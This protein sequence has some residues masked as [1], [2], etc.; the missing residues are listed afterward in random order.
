MTES[1]W[2]ILQPVLQETLA[3]TP[4]QRGLHLATLLGDNQEM[5]LLAR[6]LVQLAASSTWT[7]NLPPE[8]AGWRALVSLGQTGIGEDFLAERSDGTG[9]RLVTMRFS[10]TILQDPAS[11]QDFQDEV[12][13]LAMLYDN[14]IGR[15]IDSGLVGRNQPFLVTEFVAGIPID[16]SSRNLKTKEIVQLF[17]KVLTSVEYAH[18]RQ[19]WHGDLRPANILVGIGQSIHL[20]DFALNR[21]LAPGE[22]RIG[23]LDKSNI[24][25]NDLLYTSP[26]QIRGK[27]LSPATDIYA[28]G[29]IFYQMLGGTTPY[30]QEEK[31]VMSL[32]RAI[33][34]KIPP[35]IEGLAPELN[36]ILQ[37]ALEKNPMGRYPSVAFLAEDID[38]YLQGRS[39]TASKGA[40]SDSL[41]S[42]VTRHW[43][44][45]ALVLCMAALG[46]FAVFQR[47]SN[48]KAGQIQKATDGIFAKGM[49]PKSAGAKLPAETPVQ[50]AKKY[51]DKMLEE[52]GKQPAV[53][54][55]LSKAYL[56]LAEAEMRGFGS[57]SIDRGMAIQA[58]RRSYELSV[59][60]LDQNKSVPLT[61]QQALDYTQSAV[62]LTKLLREA[63]DYKEAARITQ[64]WQDRLAKVSSTNPN[65]LKAKALANTT[66]ADLL[67]ESGQTQDS[68]G[69][70]KNAM[71]QMGQV[72][73]ADKSNEAT[74][75]EY[76]SAARSVGS[77]SMAMN[78]FVEA[79]SAFRTS[80]KVLREQAEKPKSETAPL[81]DLAKTMSGLGE[82]FQ[83]SNQIAQAKASY[84]EAR[85]L[86]E[87]AAK[88]EANN[89]DV[90]VGLADNLVH[91]ARFNFEEKQTELSL[92]DADRAIEILR[93]LLA[94]INSAPDLR[95]QLA[96]ALTVKGEV[97]LALKRKPD[98]LP[99]LTEALSQ[100][101]N[102]GRSSGLRPGEEAEIARVRALAAR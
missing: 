80:E 51:L 37:K 63:R 79:I 88:R 82:A 24:D 70:A 97:L 85:Q 59:L 33:C 12:K 32:A 41:L 34:E 87:Q 5:Y 86:L 25:L 29:V 71:T 60:V 30:G 52:N 46:M 92:G 7:D 77:K 13:R 21:T 54:E 15:I 1:Q 28:L 76:A 93:R 78:N 17:R 69:V 36:F 68:V 26:E 58:S 42:Y 6:R 98:A 73:E 14:S 19:V 2:E 100:W 27:G 44:S 49:A 89:E 9:D 4:A 99:L 83:K 50:S 84:K 91:T 62:M 10:N 53:Q 20:A 40:V 55:E 96:L 47:G 8:F 3:M 16:E 38:R 22:D 48:V 57:P 61:D 102:F 45:I 95:R 23:A 90:L 75:R 31:D 39:T 72:Y 81:I 11:V 101:D 65:V 43:I 18:Q 94:N 35:K 64:E 56:R 74:G 67:F 66:M